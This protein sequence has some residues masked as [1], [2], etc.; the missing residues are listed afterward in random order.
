MLTITPL[1]EAGVA[2]LPFDV[3]WNGS[4]GDFVADPVFGLQ[5]RDPI[6]TAVVLLLFSD[7]RGSDAALARAGESDP[8]GWVGDGF[9]V[10]RAGG[11][12]P[13]GSTL[14]LLRR[15]ALTDAVVRQ[16]EDAARQALQPLI[17]QGAVARIEISTAP[18][19]ARRI[20]GLSVALF[21]RDGGRRYAARFD[22][23]W[24]G[25]RAL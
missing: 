18:D 1:E 14:W 7:A 19:A 17:R 5:A 3:V 12:A 25:A 4:A 6:A 2:L 22:I 10:D 21:G 16:V 13:L 15:E 20:L 24:R 8:R 11:E 23:L 9:D